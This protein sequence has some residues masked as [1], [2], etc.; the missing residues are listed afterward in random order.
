MNQRFTKL[1]SLPE[2]LYSEGSPVIISAGA[3]LQDNVSGKIL[4]QLKFRKIGNV[5][6]RSI[7][8]EII[9]S[10]TAGRALGEPVIFPYL[11]LQNTDVEFGSKV[12]VYLLDNTARFFRARVIE[13]VFDD[14]TVWEDIGGTWESLP[15]QAELNMETELLKQYKLEYGQ[16]CRFNVTKVK[17]LWYCT[18]GNLNKRN[19]CP[20]GLT[21]RALENVNIAELT[22]HM[23]S[24]LEEEKR[25]K[26]ENDAKANKRK[27]KVKII[28]K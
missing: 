26:L 22:A 23:N 3:L 16:Q 8:V 9:A 1:F 24:R 2:R 7:K 28:V 6:L 17:D 10:D 14:G 27:N 21:L 4:V 19:S 25:I 15:V 5:Y 20:C 18:C 12:P 13:A 11:D